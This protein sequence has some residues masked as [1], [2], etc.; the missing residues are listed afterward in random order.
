MPGHEGDGAVKHNP[1]LGNCTCFSKSC[2][3]GIEPGKSR[4]WVNRRQGFHRFVG[5]GNVC[6]K[7]Y[8]H[9]NLPQRTLTE[10]FLT[11]DFDDSW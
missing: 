11:R 2:S 5:Y 4:S 7:W 3:Q 1:L 6:G 8:P 9:S 10:P